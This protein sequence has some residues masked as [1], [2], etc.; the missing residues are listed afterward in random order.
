[1]P[2]EPEREPLPKPPR[3]DAPPRIAV[4]APVWSTPGSAAAGCFDFTRDG[5]RLVAAAEGAE[6]VD[7]YAVRDGHKEDPIAPD[8]GKIKAVTAAGQEKVMING[9]DNESGIWDVLSGERLRRMQTPMGDVTPFSVSAD[10]K[11]AICPGQQ[12]WRVLRFGL[13]TGMTNKEWSDPDSPAKVT[14]VRYSPTGSHWVA[15]DDEAQI[16]VRD[17]MAGGQV[18]WK[19][20]SKIARTGVLSA[21]NKRLITFGA[22]PEIR[23]WD[24]PNRKLLHT[25]PGHAGGV[26]DAVLTADDRWVISVGADKELRVWDVATGRE[27]QDIDLPEAASCVRLFPKGNQVATA[28]AGGDKAAIQLWRIDESK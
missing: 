3:E 21:T 5:K 16:V 1:M 12:G 4:L 8:V 10:E 14:S 15:V 6:K 26:R 19:D 7:V 25:L 24:V 22:G 27:V 17:L 23:L 20:P 13:D 2:P 28:G 9:D 11:D 18:N